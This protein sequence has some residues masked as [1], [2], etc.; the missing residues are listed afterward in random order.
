[1]VSL[2][3]RI[4]GCLTGG[5]VGDAIGAH[6][7][8][9]SAPIL[10][11]VPNDLH[12]TD[13]T[14]LTIAT[15]ESIIATK[16]VSPEAIANQFLKWYRKRRITGIGSSTLKALSELDV[17][18]HWAMAGAT[19]ERAAGNG[20]AMRIAPLAFLLDPN[21]DSHRQTIR[22]VCRITHRHDEAYLG[23]LAIVRSI[24][25]VVTGMPLD[26]RLLSHLVETLPDCRVRDRIIEIRQISPT[27]PQYVE[28]F[29]SSGY[30]VDSVPLA[31]LAAIQGTNFLPTIEQIVMCGGDTDTIA[32]MFGQIY[33]AAYCCEALPMQYADRLDERDLLTEV[34]KGIAELCSIN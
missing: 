20:A 13:D 2:A 34:S 15:C 16:I 11:R 27:I 4:A 32:S 10:F 3:D 14:Q 17:G 7:E 6:F 5:A 9:K 21:L 1:M 33:G 25:Y 8:G 31:I 22:D 24:A 26:A 30:V 29:T 12:V 28:R 18:G 19:G 23:A